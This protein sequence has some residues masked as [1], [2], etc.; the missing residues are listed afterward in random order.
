MIH[1]T[2]PGRNNTNSFETE[3]IKVELGTYA[4]ESFQM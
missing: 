3:G 4:D 2:V 1:I